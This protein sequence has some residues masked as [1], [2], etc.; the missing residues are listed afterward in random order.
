MDQLSL[1]HVS[2][3]QKQSRT[4]RD[5]SEKCLTVESAM[6]DGMQGHKLEANRDLVDP[7]LLQEL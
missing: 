4:R 6:N 3:L 2:R 7:Y 1:Q 5:N